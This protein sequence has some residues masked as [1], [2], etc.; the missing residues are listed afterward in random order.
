MD[1]HHFLLCVNTY[2]SCHG[3]IP[4]TLLMEQLNGLSVAVHWGPEWTPHQV[5]LHFL[6]CLPPRP[7]GV[8]ASR[9][10]LPLEEWS[11]HLPTFPGP[12]SSFP[13]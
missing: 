12:H 9:D 11:A 6:Q 4:K 5:Q 10:L 13:D 2:R 1:S 3:I 7:L 8:L